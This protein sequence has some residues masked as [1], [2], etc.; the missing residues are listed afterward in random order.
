MYH[1]NQS[2]EL[3]SKAIFGLSTLNWRGINY[4]G[5]GYI[6]RV[7]QCNLRVTLPTFRIFSFQFLTM[8]SSVYAVYG[9]E[10]RRQFA[11][12]LLYSQLQVTQVCHVD[13]PCLHCLPWQQGGAYVV[14]VHPWTGVLCTVSTWLWQDH[15]NY[16]AENKTSYFTWF[17]P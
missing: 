3:N 8:L 4:F 17:V 1:D 10:V 7:E 2:Q 9:R 16:K 13:H 15:H 12:T 6:L 11:L 5:Y 14:S